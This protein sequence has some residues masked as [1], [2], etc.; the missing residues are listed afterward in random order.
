LK[1]PGV[2]LSLDDYASGYSSL[3]VLQR[4]LLDE[5]KIYRSFISSMLNNQ[6]DA[7]I[8]KGIISMGI[9]LCMEV[10]A[11]DVETTSLETFL[12]ESG[13]LNYQAYLFSRP[14]PI[15]EFEEKFA[16]V[17]LDQIKSI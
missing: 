16:S 10:I 15:A 1:N 2:S 4:F 7:V 8:T 13:C 5:L 3:S 6:N 9:I 11:K 14:V 17:S 12:R